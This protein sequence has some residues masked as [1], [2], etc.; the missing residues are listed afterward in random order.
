MTERPSDGVMT[1][2]G[3]RTES[4]RRGKRTGRRG[5]T[6]RRPKAIA[7]RALGAG[8]HLG[9]VNLLAMDY[10]LAAARG[11]MVAEAVLALGAAPTATA[12]G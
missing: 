12:W 5:L 9:P 11:H 4:P 8:V 6:R 3:A 10:G 2:D 7:H 1:P